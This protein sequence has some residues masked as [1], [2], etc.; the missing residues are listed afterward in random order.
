[1]MLLFKISV[2]CGSDLQP[3]VQLS[4]YQYTFYFG[5]RHIQSDCF[6]RLV[7]SRYAMCNKTWL[8]FQKAFCLLLLVFYEQFNDEY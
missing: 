3:P 8:K 6:D 7:C 4:N 5:T 2:Q 1:M